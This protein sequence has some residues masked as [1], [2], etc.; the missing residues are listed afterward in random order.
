[1]TEAA[2]IARRNYLNQ[3]RKKNPDKVKAQNA[4]YWERKAAKQMTGENA[5]EGE[6]QENARVQDDRQS[7]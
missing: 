7:L 2:K 3:W 4:R 5:L 6:V 1:M